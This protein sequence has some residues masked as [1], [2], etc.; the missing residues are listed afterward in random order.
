MDPSFYASS[1]NIDLFK[2][3]YISTQENKKKI[4]HLLAKS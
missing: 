1:N 4:L 3:L 2:L